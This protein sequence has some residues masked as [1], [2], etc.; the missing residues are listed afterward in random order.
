MNQSEEGERLKEEEQK[1]PFKKIG[2]LIILGILFCILIRYAYDFSWTVSLIVSPIIT[3]IVFLIEKFKTP[4]TEEEKQKEKE[5][6]ERKKLEEEIWKKELDNK[7]TC[8]LMREQEKYQSRLD[9]LN[10]TINK[11]TN[12]NFGLKFAEFGIIVFFIGILYL[13]SLNGFYFERQAYVDN[14]YSTM[15][16]VNNTLIDVA[17]FISNKSG[18]LFTK[19]YDIG[20]SKP[21]IFFWLWWI[22]IVW[23]IGYMFLWQI[24]KMDWWVI[25]TIKSKV[26]D[27]YKRKRHQN[28]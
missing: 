4:K 19:L 18:D 9:T 12:S 24:F 3:I 15:D 8:E 20:T 28:E 16:L 1:K 13:G 17:G 23:W 25:K 22:T 2:L 6:K 27:Y 14:I 5:E 11:R 10:F 26:S 21:T 7:V